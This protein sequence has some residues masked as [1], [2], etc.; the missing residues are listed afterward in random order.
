MPRHICFKTNVTKYVEIVCPVEDKS[1]IPATPTNLCVGDDQAHPQD[2]Q[3]A[4]N[5]RLRDPD[6]RCAPERLEV[7]DDDQA[8]LRHQ[9]V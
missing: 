6:L 2:L 7:A 1:L 8:N 3:P 4:R 9:D 5:R